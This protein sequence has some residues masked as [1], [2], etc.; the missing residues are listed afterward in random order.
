VAATGSSMSVAVYV[1]VL[2]LISFV[3][4]L[5]VKQS[6]VDRGSADLDAAHAGTAEVVQ[7]A[8]RATA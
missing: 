8:Q 1:A 7:G 2:S 3:S 5:A 4:V 6:A